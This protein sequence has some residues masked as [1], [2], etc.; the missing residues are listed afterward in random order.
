MEVM[1]MGIFIFISGLIVGAGIGVNLS[2]I[3]I[4]GRSKD[5]EDR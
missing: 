2:M 5:D 1:L 3:C 4:S